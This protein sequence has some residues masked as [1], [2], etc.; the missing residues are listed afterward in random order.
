LYD[1]LNYRS[2][3]FGLFSLCII[4]FVFIH[5]CHNNGA[6]EPNSGLQNTPRWH[7]LNNFTRARRGL[8]AV[9]NNGYLYVVGG[10]DKNGNYVTDVEFAK[11]Y[12]DGTIGQWRS[13]HALLQGRI[14]TA[15]I[16]HN[17]YLYVIGGG[18]GKLG[19]ENHPV[20]SVEKAH[21]FESGQ[22]GPWEFEKPLG[23]P[24]RGLK[25]AKYN[26]FIY[27]IGGY[28]GTFLKSVETAKLTPSG[29]IIQ[30]VME[31]ET[32]KIERY[33]HSATIYKNIMYLLGGHMH[34]PDVMSYGDVESAKITRNGQ[35]E[36]WRIEQSILNT[37][38]FIA[39]ATAVDN[40][41][42]MIGGHN[43]RNR[44]DSVEVTSILPSGKIGTWKYS[45][46]LAMARSAAAIA[47]NGKFIYVLGGMSE[48]GI[49]NS[50]EVLG[51]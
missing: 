44:L 49:L 4:P 33:I 1:S 10:V 25:T 47:K 23:T 28:N 5:S 51:L 17:G 6:S 42:Y 38:R 45:Q 36:P 24:R 8:A 21:F 27:A 50:V 46:P 15:A 26:N 19:D 43:G 22:L 35:I 16:S 11:I 14:Y 34:N 29:E 48:L 13:T 9:A 18:S 2:K 41:L 12:P 20:A 32:S 37:P 7:L 39:M 30:W 3:L 31:N 40:K